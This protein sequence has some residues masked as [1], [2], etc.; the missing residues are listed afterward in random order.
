MPDTSPQAEERLRQIRIVA[1]NMLDRLS[2]LL[3][4]DYKLTL[5][6][7]HTKLPNAQMVVT[8]ENDTDFEAIVHALMTARPK[9]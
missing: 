4:P 8:E 5:V 3:P 1:G 7:R 2:Q 9:Q 6:A